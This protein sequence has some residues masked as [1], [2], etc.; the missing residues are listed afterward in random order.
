MLDE[1]VLL[2]QRYGKVED[3]RTL[4]ALQLGAYFLLQ[5]ER[6]AFV[7]ADKNLSSIAVRAGCEVIDPAAEK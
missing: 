6:W 2:L 5:G 1:A 7:C 3:L 4:D